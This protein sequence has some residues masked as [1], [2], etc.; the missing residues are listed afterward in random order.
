MLSVSP[1]MVFG[2]LCKFWKYILPK[3]ND[4]T[5]YHGFV[6][7]ALSS[8]KGF[9]PMRCFPKLYLWIVS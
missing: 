1:N 7:N 9:G 6:L 5:V 4:I 2:Y 8:V 3:S